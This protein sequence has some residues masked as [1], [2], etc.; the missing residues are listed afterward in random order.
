MTIK[1]QQN[2]EKSE[3]QNKVY[4]QFFFLQRQI[5]L[6]LLKVGFSHLQTQ[7]MSTLNNDNNKLISLPIEMAPIYRRHCTLYVPFGWS[8]TIQLI[9]IS[10]TNDNTLFEYFP[11]F[12]FLFCH[13]KQQSVRFFVCHIAHC[14]DV[15]TS[16]AMRQFV[17]K[18]FGMAKVLKW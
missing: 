8:N 6:M 1:S 2:S 4:V 3:G 12:I 13:T 18:T 11:K 14:N 9:N 10:P 15:S 16:F 17:H 7:T 5:C